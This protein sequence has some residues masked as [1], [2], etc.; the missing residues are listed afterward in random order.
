MAW[1]CVAAAHAC[2][3]AGEMRASAAG[4]MVI[5]STA[6]VRA[7]HLAGMREIVV[8]RIQPPGLSASISRGC[9][10]GF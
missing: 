7:T 5:A 2:F 9:R 3:A 4:A 10:S 1:S 8:M 6:T